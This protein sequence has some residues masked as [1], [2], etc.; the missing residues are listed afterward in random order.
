MDAARPVTGVTPLDAVQMAIT[1]VKET[2][3]VHPV[4]PAARVEDVVNQDTLVLW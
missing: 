4:R 3:V 1:A 2:L